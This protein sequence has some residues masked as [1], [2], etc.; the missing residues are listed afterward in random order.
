M[1]EPSL[2]QGDNPCSLG[3]G[4]GNGTIRELKEAFKR[5]EQEQATA[6]NTT[7]LAAFSKKDRRHI[8]RRARLDGAES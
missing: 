8:W 5:G 3:R 2:N 7:S 6:A 1:S 4:S